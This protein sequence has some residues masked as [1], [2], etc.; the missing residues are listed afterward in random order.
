MFNNNCSQVV[1]RTGE[2]DICYYNF[3]CSYRL[4][5]FSDFNH[6]WSNIS[7]VLFGASFNFIV[8]RRERNLR[9][10]ALKAKEVSAAEDG[11]D[12]VKNICKC[13]CIP[14]KFVGCCC[15]KVIHARTDYGIPLHFGVFYAMGLALIMEGFLSAAYHLCPNQSNFQFGKKNSLY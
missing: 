12:D 14:E 13:T 15:A 8:G 7:Y 11:T 10:N 3:L 1:N 4:W 9:L 5:I 2:F 6:F